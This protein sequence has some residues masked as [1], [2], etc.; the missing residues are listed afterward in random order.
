MPQHHTRAGVRTTARMLPWL[1]LFLLPLGGCFSQPR[2]T[3]PIC[4]GKALMV[5][6]SDG[7][8]YE[9]QESC[10]DGN[11]CTLD[12][13]QNGACVF[14]AAPES[15]LAC[16]DGNPCTND[17]CAG[18][19]KH[20]PAV[21]VACGTG[22][23]CS[24]FASCV[25]ADPTKAGPECD[26]CADDLKLA[27]ACT[28]C[29]DPT[30]T[31]PHCDQCLDPK[32]AGYFCDSCAD[33]EKTGPDCDQCADPLRTG[34]DCS[35]CQNP[36]ARWPSCQTCAEQ[37]GLRG[38][39]CDTGETC[40]L[41][42]CVEFAVGK[43]CAGSCYE[44]CPEGQVCK[45]LDFGLDQIG[46][47]L[48]PSPH[49]CSPCLVNKDCHSL[50]VT[51]DRCIPHGTDGAFCGLACSGQPCP[52]G[53][54]CQSMPDVDGWA[55]MQCVVKDGGVCTCNALANQQ[56][57][58]TTCSVVSGDS[59]CVGQR[60]CLPAA[61]PGAPKGGGLTACALPES[62]TPVCSDPQG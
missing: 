55:S 21:G 46:L 15:S 28:A 13:C 42:L 10:F 4:I 24:A 59:E 45:W 40:D 54:T 26:V 35:K 57:M 52:E 38:C 37:P 33:S 53:Y 36:L 23:V 19:C 48:D 17:L 44:G 20:V 34:A 1:L 11:P 47:C 50:G 12:G 7:H 18:N 2:C 8:G 58:S 43:R 9:L 31:G 22:K 6:R 25:C 32:K 27:P 61:A 51:D 39:P 60:A 14:P 30:K 3:G 5:C 56:Q 29:V 16:D 62:A 41:G 49:L